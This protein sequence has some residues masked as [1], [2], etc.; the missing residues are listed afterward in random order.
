MYLFT[1]ILYLY[2]YLYLFKYNRCIYCLD[3]HS[4]RTCHCIA[5]NKGITITY[6]NVPFLSYVNCLSAPYSLN[7][8]KEMTSEVF[9][10]SAI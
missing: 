9:V 4:V 10:L 5:V 2:L 7:S 6:G 1:F 3:S 8:E